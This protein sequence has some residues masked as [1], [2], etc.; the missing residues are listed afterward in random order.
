MAN[1]PC[2]K[3]D[4]MSRANL[5]K[6][7]EVVRDMMM[8]D[9]RNEV[10]ALRAENERLREELSIVRAIAPAVQPWWQWV[11]PGWVD[12]AGTHTTPPPGCDVQVMQ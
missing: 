12:T 6:V 11:P 1:T 4:E 5:R 10:A 7:A 2:K 3:L 8:E 9:L